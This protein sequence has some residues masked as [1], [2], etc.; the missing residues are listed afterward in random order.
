MTP[1]RAGQ[2]RQ[3]DD[4]HRRDR[5]PEGDDPGHD[6]GL[7]PVG[8]RQDARQ[9]RGQQRGQDTGGQH[10]GGRQP[11]QH[12]DLPGRRATS[13]Q[14]P[15]APLV[16]RP[17][18]QAR[19]PQPHQ[20]DEHEQGRRSGDG[21]TG[22]DTVGDGPLEG[23]RQSGPHRETVEQGRLLER[24]HGV[25]HGRLQPRR[26]RRRH[27]PPGGRRS[28]AERGHRVARDQQ[29]PHGAEVALADPRPT[30][31]VVGPPWGVGGSSPVGAADPQAG[32]VRLR[33][34]QPAEGEG[35]PHAPPQTL[36]RNLRDRDVAVRGG[37]GPAHQRAARDGARGVP[38]L[39]PQVGGGARHG[40]AGR[41]DPPGHLGARD[42]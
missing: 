20:G 18:Q 42:A 14:E 17:E 5:G 13:A 41:G 24:G 36:G 26:V 28:C 21:G 3:G 31:R 10:G 6:G 1:D 11:G 32:W 35:L 40:V 9:H 2:R 12:P 15:V 4:Q 19:Q 34:H 38:Q 22:A 37:P 39:H 30:A 8:P 27:D 7:D 33:G 29:R 16:D 23:R 25:T